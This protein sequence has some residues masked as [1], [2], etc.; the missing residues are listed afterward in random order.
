MEPFDLLYG[1]DMSKRKDK[2]SWRKAQQDYKP[3]LVVVETE[4]TDWIIFYENLNYKGKDR[5][6]GKRK[7]QYPLVEEGVQSCYQQIAD[8][9][10]FLCLLYTSPS[11]RDA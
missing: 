7:L 5:M 1:K 4:C 11:P 8:G 3:L 6:E 10:C 2:M 9:N